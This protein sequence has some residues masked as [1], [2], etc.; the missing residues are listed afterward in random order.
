MSWNLSRNHSDPHNLRPINWSS[1]CQMVE[2]LYLTL[3]RV[4]G[5]PHPHRTAWAL[6]GDETERPRKKWNSIDARH[7]DDD[8]LFQVKLATGERG[9][10]CKNTPVISA[11]SRY[12]G[13]TGWV[14]LK[15]RNSNPKVN[16]LLFLQPWGKMMTL[17]PFQAVVYSGCGYQQGTRPLV[18]F[19]WKIVVSKWKEKV[20]VSFILPSVYGPL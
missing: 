5:C 19:E 13:S 11:H 4:G 12:S 18:Q 1:R 9:T 2:N 20:L 14:E 15:R 17:L 3:C 7:N 16:I 8:S 6:W 10:K